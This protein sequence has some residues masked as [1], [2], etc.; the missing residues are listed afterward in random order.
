MYLY[1]LQSGPKEPLGEVLPIQAVL[2]RVLG[3]DDTKIANL[4]VQGLSFHSPLETFGFSTDKSVSP[5][6]VEGAFAKEIDIY[7]IIRANTTITN[8]SMSILS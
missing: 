5:V 6:P 8:P 2:V 1:V 3:A 4:I 7:A